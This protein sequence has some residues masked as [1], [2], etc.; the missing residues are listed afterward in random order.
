MLIVSYSTVG[1]I[2]HC[3]ID[4]VVD[5]TVSFPV[6]QDFTVGSTAYC[7]PV[8]EGHPVPECSKVDSIM[9]SVVLQC[10]TELVHHNTE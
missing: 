8:P 5:S 7:E 4:S 3:T 9:D 2:V 1:S 10:P 6:G